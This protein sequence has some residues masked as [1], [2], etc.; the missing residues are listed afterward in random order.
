MLTKEDI[1][2]AI[3]WIHT[4]AITV[5]DI[6]REYEERVQRRDISVFKSCL[7]RVP[8]NN[9]SIEWYIS[10]LDEAK[11][12]KEELIKE[13]C[14]DVEPMILDNRITLIY[15]EIKPFNEFVDWRGNTQTSTFGF[16]T[17][18]NRVKS[19]IKEL[20]WL[21]HNHWWVRLI[22]VKLFLEWK[23]TEED[24]KSLIQ[25]KDID[26]QN[27]ILEMVPE[28]TKPLVITN[29]DNTLRLKN[30]DNWFVFINN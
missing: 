29:E 15:N 17:W 25:C 19:I 11:K 2:W 16:N 5:D 4:N 8:V 27:D 18:Q 7:W 14:F 1:Y 28:W 9:T 10:A 13:W 12:K 6:R 20:L 22:Y 24:L 21:D 23:I 30:S 3:V 26:V